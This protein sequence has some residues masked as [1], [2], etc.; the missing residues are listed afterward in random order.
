MARALDRRATVGGK[1]SFAGTRRAA[2]PV[3]SQWTRTGVIGGREGAVTSRGYIRGS[4]ELIAALQRLG[5]GT[6]DELLARA[7]YKGAKVLAD[8]WRDRV[9]VKDGNY[10]EAI[11]ARSKAGRIGATGIVSLRLVPG[12]AKNDQ[13]RLYA[14]RLEF[15]S[16]RYSKEQYMSTLHGL[17]DGLPTGRARRAQPS[18]RPAFDSCSGQMLDSMSDEIRRLI[19]AVT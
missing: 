5:Q 16:A 18:L 8:E 11:F 10:R 19:E 2:G 3:R 7:T 15:G 6:K 13:P 12:L 9:P 4:A 1:T 17:S 14:S